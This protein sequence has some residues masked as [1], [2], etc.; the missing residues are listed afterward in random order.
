MTMQM[1]TANILLYLFMAFNETELP[2]VIS[3]LVSNTLSYH[4]LSL[5]ILWHFFPISF[6]Q[7]RNQNHLKSLLL[8]FPVCPY[9]AFAENATE[10]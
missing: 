10:P 8:Y 2:V 7:W 3:T 4:N 6:F 1:E 9:A 5:K